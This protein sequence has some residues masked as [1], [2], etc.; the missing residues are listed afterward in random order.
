MGSAEP[1][2]EVTPAADSSGRL[3][4]LRHPILQHSRF[5]RV[6]AALAL[7]LVGLFI[8]WWFHFRPFVSTDD[9]RVAAPLIVIAPQGSGGRVD[10]V[11]V[12][13]GQT[14]RA[15]EPLV[16]LDASAERSQVDRARALLALADARVGEAEAQL[17]LESRLSEATERRARAGVHSAQASQ[18]RTTR[19]ARSEEVARAR[20]DVAVAETVTVQARRDLDRAESLAR[21]GAIAQ[22]SLET[23]RTAE[24]AARASLESKQAMLDLL[25]HGNRPEDISIAQSGVLAAQAGL[26]DASGG[27]DRVA[28]RT[29]QVEASRAQAAQA[30]AELTLAEVALARMTLK[31]SVGG[32]VVRVPVD[33]GDYLSPGQ[34]AITIIDIAHAWIAANVEETAS[35]LLRMGQVA[36]ISIDE[37]GDL[38]GRVDVITQSAASAFALIPADNAAGNYTKVVQRIPIRIAIDA[39]PRVQALRA[40]QSVVVRIRVR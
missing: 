30:R 40:G 7:V 32:V 11:L 25:A 38:S 3:Y 1:A 35:G 22:V 18:D 2:V 9:A 19:G 8:L 14:V 17:R 5:R 16:E 6:V 28:F 20:A 24:S 4:F 15:S 13:E 10:R 21:E 31:S 33:P 27:V 23:A 29:R 37:G 12:R 39:S 34:G 36:D 26:L